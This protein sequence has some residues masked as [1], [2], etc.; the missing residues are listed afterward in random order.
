[1][2]AIEGYVRQVM[3]FVPPALPERGAIEID[4][5]AHLEEGAAEASPE[6]AVSRMGAA[7]DVAVGYLRARPLQP[8]TIGKRMLAFLVDVALGVTLVASTL[9]LVVANFGLV[10]LS[11]DN[12]VQLGGLALI[13]VIVAVGSVS[14]LSLMYFPLMEWRFGQTLGKK[15]MGIHVVRADG[16]AIGLGAA[17][18]RRIPFFLEFFWIDAVVA[19]FT[20]RRQRAFD[21]VAGTLV[22]EGAG[23]GSPRQVTRPVP[24]A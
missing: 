13:G 22:V 3:E 14:A 23:A 10:A 19:L 18:V 20:E 5:R 8:T 9:L 2:S 15:L 16:L 24:A 11:A 4:L 17:V 21:L 1:M 12:D 6:I 7:R